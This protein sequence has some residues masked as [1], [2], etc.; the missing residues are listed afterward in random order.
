MYEVAFVVEG[1]QSKGSFE[2][3]QLTIVD[4]GSPV[5]IDKNEIDET[6]KVEINSTDI[7]VSFDS[8][9]ETKNVALYNIAGN[10]IV[11]YK[12]TNSDSVTFN[13]LE[14]GFYVVVVASNNT[15]MSQKVI[16]N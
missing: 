6:T 15:K 11:E 7:K 1:Y 9:N 5:S 14:K 8:K 3:K 2:F 16:I 4:D 10:S 13:N 12:N